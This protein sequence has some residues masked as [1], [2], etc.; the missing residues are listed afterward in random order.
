MAVDRLAELKQLCC[1][2]GNSIAGTSPALANPVMTRTPTNAS[3]A[4][5]AGVRIY[6]WARSVQ[7][8]TP[9]AP[10]GIR[11]GKG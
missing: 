2:Y 5:V 10:G 11:W 4:I 6:P 9:T 7:R 8:L 1:S 3:R